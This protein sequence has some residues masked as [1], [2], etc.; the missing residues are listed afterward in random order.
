MAK[1]VKVIIPVYKLELSVLELQSLKQAYSILEDYE[2]VIAKPSSLDLSEYLINF[3]KLKFQSFDDSYFKGIHGYNKLMRSNT[4]YKCFLDVDYILIYQLD[5]YV[6]RNELQYFMNKGYDYIGA[7]WLRRRLYNIF[8]FLEKIKLAKKKHHREKITW[9][10]NDSNCVGNGGLSLRKVQSFYKIT[11][12]YAERISFYDSQVNISLF[13][14][15]VFWAKEPLEFNYPSIKEA[16]EFS[17]DKYPKFCYKKNKKQLPMGCH[18][19]YKWKWRSFWEKYIEFE[20]YVE[21]EPYFSKKISIIISQLIFA[22]KS[23]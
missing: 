12:K 14:E 8:P 15:D 16:L 22:K 23:I 6:F 9:Q 21:K 7:P 1:T 17:F 5:S 13:N 3:P 20:N 11:L 10:Q 4:F 2:I 19:W 18:G